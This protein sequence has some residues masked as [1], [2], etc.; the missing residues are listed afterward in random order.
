M[1]SCSTSRQNNPGCLLRISY[2]SNMSALFRGLLVRR[3]GLDQLRGI[4]V[5]DAHRWRGRFKSRAFNGMIV[6][7]SGKH[8]DVGP[9]FGLSKANRRAV[10]K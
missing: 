8:A 7:R 3:L 4:C 6:H 1:Y 5:R 2:T 10:S 9:N